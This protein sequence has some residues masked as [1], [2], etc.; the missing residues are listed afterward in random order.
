MID[1]AVVGSGPNGL[2]AAVAL[3]QRGLEVT[4]FE[5]AAEIGGGTRTGELMVAGVRH[6]I[7]SAVH[8]LAVASPFLRSLPLERHGL[9]WRWP[10]VDLAHPLD[11]GQAGVLAG[12]VDD[13]SSG[14]GADGPAWRRVFGPVA[15][16]LDALIT[17]VF[18][19]APRPP[20][21]RSVWP[22]SASGRCSPPP[23]WPGAGGATRPEP[24]LGEWQRTGS[25]PWRRW[26][27]PRSGS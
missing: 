14:L 17:D 8:P 16:R 13:T 11:S 22:G 2:A 7:C 9:R 20:G 1:A 6:D 27:P 5:A 10:E 12:S 3:A 15:H 18:R 23:S 19:P 25:S 4:V 24:C 26:R 21:I